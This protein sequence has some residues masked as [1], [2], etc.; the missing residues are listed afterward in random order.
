MNILTLTNGW[1]LKGDYSEESGKL[2]NGSVVRQWKT[3]QGIGELLL[4]PNIQPILDPLP[5][6]VNINKDYIIFWM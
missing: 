2:T 6:I 4:N 1:V 3:T 5:P